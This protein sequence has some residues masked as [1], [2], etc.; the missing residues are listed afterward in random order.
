VA[1]LPGH[2]CRQSPRNNGIRYPPEPPTV[3]EILAAMCRAGDRAY[4]LRLR[5]L[6]VVL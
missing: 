6:I 5:R 4:G 1:T 3:K 2:R